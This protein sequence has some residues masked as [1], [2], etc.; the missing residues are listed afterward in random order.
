[1]SSKNQTQTS[2]KKTE[3]VSQVTTKPNQKL[4]ESFEE[5]TP[6]EL[7]YLDKYKAI[8]GDAMDDEEIYD[9][10]TKHN[11]DDVKI[12]SDV[13]SYLKLVQKKGDD[14]G[15]NKIEGGKSKQEALII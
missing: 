1:M 11:F 15:W 3:T 6:K 7:A 13:D 2:T 8:S 5:Y 14:F 4:E 10:I 12:R 9:I